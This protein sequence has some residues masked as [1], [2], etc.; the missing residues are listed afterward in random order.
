LLSLAE[1]CPRY[2]FGQLFQLIR[3]RGHSLNHKRVCRI[4]CALKLNLRRKGKKRLPTRTPQPL[5]IHDQFEI[6]ATDRTDRLGSP[7]VG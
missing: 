1:R 7:E 2:G 4:Y 6:V 3:R 5:A